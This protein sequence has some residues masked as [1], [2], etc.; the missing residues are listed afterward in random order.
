ME[1]TWIRHL[2]LQPPQLTPRIS[3]KHMF[4]STQHLQ[5]QNHLTHPIQP[6]SPQQLR[7]FQLSPTRA[8]TSKRP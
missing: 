3:S 8:S 7:S 6:T 1:T 4:S 5:Q 2:H